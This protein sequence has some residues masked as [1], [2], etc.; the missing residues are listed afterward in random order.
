M[1]AV[2]A[3]TMMRSTRASPPRSRAHTLAA[4]GRER[5]AARSRSSRSHGIGEIRPGDELAPLIADAAAAQDTPLLDG[6]CLV[7]TQKIVSKAEGRLV[8]ARSRRPRRAPR[9]RRVGVGAHRAPPRRPHHQ[10]DPARVRVRERGHR[11]LERRRRVGRAAARRLRPLGQA[12][13]RRAARRAP[14]SRSASIVS[15]TFGR[16]WRQGLTDVAIGVSRDRRGR[17]PARH[18]PTRSAASCRSP[19]SRSPTRSRRRPSS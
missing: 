18:R 13:P 14:A 16:P 3:D 17:R 10:R 19:R 15:D 2:V 12:H 1:R 6:D 9:A 4:V 5:G 7:V 11:P 8:R